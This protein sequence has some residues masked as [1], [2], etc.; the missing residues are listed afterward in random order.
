MLQNPVDC[1]IPVPAGVLWDPTLTHLLSWVPH[2]IK[3]DCTV[4][5][6][7][8]SSGSQPGN[9]DLKS[10]FRAGISQPSC[11]TLLEE[12]NPFPEDPQS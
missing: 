11:F 12:F 4:R 10:I 6:L 9:R 7:S 3:E 2:H 5:G 1:A 8:D